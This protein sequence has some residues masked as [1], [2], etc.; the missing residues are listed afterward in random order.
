MSDVAG[1][2]PHFAF[3]VNFTYHVKTK[4]RAWFHSEITNPGRT[5]FY[6]TTTR[7]RITQA[8]RG[9]WLHPPP[10]PPPPVPQLCHLDRTA[11]AAPR[12]GR[13]ARLLLETPG[14]LRASR[15]AARPS[16]PGMTA[17]S[18]SAPPL[19]WQGCSTWPFST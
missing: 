15:S 7:N 8:G 13:L 16:A 11:A 9:E 3:T 1:I 2:S 6:F 12:R 18:D 14:P 17:E 4:G 5:A 19:P 10:L